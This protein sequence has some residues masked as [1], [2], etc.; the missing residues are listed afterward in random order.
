VNSYNPKL[1]IYLTGWIGTPIHELGHAIFCIIFGH[2]ITAIKL[3]GPNSLDGTLGYVYNSYNADN[4]YQK[5]GTLFIGAGPIIL[6]SFILYTLMY[7]LVPNH[8]EISKLLSTRIVQNLSISNVWDN[9]TRILLIGINIIT[10]IFSFSN[11]SSITFF[12]FLYLSLCIG[13]HM[14]LSPP[15]LKGMWP[16]LVIIAIGLLVV[17]IFAVLIGQDISKNLLGITAYA[18]SLTGLF[19]YSLII[20]LINFLITYAVFASLH[21]NKYKIILSLR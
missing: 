17:N 19:I 15:D 14:Q 6:G 20:S 9:L 12:I 8:N 11:F 13:S 18:G 4:Y 5:I 16:G 10:L 3:F 21:Y 7:F 2:K 1:D